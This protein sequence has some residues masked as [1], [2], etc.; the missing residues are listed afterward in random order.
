MVFTP[1][2]WHQ[3]KSLFEAALQHA[4]EARSRF[5]EDNCSDPEIREEVLRLVINYDEMGSFLSM[6]G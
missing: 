2:R 5:L 1:P 4:P 3:V 6:M